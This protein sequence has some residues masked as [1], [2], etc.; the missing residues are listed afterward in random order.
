MERAAENDTG[1]HLSNI[2]LLHCKYLVVLRE[3]ECHVL[4]IS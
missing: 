2:L 1:S 4:H 3:T